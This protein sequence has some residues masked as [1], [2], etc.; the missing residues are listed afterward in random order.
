MTPKAWVTKEK[1]DILDSIKILNFCASE[2]YQ[3]SEKTA[4]RLGDNI[5]KS[6]VNEGLMFSMYKEPLQLNNIKTD[7]I[8][9][10]SR[11]LPKNVDFLFV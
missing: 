1:I 11:I 5:S 9:T 4:Y 10:H 6:P 2:V 7:H 8:H 3:E